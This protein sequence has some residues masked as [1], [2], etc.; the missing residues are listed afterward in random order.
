MKGLR[1]WMQEN[2][3]RNT[4]SFTHFLLDG[5]KFYFSPEKEREFL[6]RY[7]DAILLKETH[8]VVEIKTELVKMF[9][10]ID[11]EEPLENGRVWTDDS[12]F[13]LA[14]CISSKVNSF[15]ESDGKHE[16]MVCSTNSQNKIGKGVVKYGIHFIWPTLI[17][18]PFDAGVIRDAV[19]HYMESASAG[20]QTLDWLSRGARGQNSWSDV[21]DSCVY[22]PNGFRLLG[23]DKFDPKRRVP[24][25]RPYFVL[26][27]KSRKLPIYE[28]IV[29]ASIRCDVRRVSST[30]MCI[31]DWAVSCLESLKIDKT[32]SDYQGTTFKRKVG[33]EKFVDNGVALTKYLKKYL[34]EKGYPLEGR[35]VIKKIV[36]APAKSG[37]SESGNPQKLEGGYWISV[38][39][40]YCK[41]VGR[42]HSRSGPYFLLTKKGIVQRCFCVKDNQV[43]P[44]CRHFAAKIYPIDS[45]VLRTVFASEKTSFNL[46][47]SKDRLDALDRFLKYLD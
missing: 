2:S 13:E 25:K 35:F 4:R 45:S 41:N 7:A 36:E 10:D 31:P 30:E 22:G 23:S 21:I 42:N 44:H 33:L 1:K 39:T 3:L 14:D 32:K 19:V 47:N 16:A 12:I 34:R 46:G 17:V 20:S 38:N 11:I 15:F 40:M 24:L 8:Y 28:Q 26:D 37:I 6:E 5:G 9:M 43:E 18:T 27:P 29:Q